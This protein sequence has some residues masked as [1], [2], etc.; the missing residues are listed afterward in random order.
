MKNMEKILMPPPIETEIQ[1]IDGKS[2]VL[3]AKS[4]SRKTMSEITKAAQGDSSDALNNQ[5]AVLFGGQ[6]S[7]Y[8]NVD[9][10]VIKKVL[11]RVTEEITGKANPT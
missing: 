5:M 4:I 6:M 7:D 11:E 8:D 10:R 2:I 3:V 1:D 9:I